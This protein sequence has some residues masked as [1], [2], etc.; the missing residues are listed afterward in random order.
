MSDTKADE[1]R[2]SEKL[3]MY[4]AALKLI[5]NIHVRH[6]QHLGMERFSGIAGRCIPCICALALGRT[7]DE[8]WLQMFD[9]EL[10]KIEGEGHARQ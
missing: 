7:G 6:H 5:W 10:L 8:P 2:L 9:D 4:E 1:D 3:R